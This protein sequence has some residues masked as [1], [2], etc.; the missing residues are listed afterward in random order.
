MTRASSWSTIPA[1]ITRSV[2][3]ATEIAIA[4]GSRRQRPP[5]RAYPCLPPHLRTRPPIRRQAS[6]ARQCSRSCVRRGAG[7]VHGMAKADRGRCDLGPHRPAH[8]EDVRATTTSCVE[9][10]SNPVAVGKK[11]CVVGPRLMSAAVGSPIQHSRC[12]RRAD[13]GIEGR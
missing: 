13:V 3:A 8:G 7:N 2:I 11:V 5:Q 12:M 9:R 1:T 10:G 6:Q 4:E